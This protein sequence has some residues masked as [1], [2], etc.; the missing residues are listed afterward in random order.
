MV[1][2]GF[3]ARQFF[4]LL[5]W[6]RLTHLVF[7]YFCSTKFRIRSFFGSL[8]RFISSRCCINSLFSSSCSSRVSSLIPYTGFENVFSLLNDKRIRRSAC[9][10]SSLITT[11]QFLPSVYFPVLLSSIILPSTATCEI[12]EFDRIAPDC[13]LT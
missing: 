12:I 7:I 5:V 3:D 6:S 2:A 10:M 8:F 4:S 13:C 1:R 9:W 11:V